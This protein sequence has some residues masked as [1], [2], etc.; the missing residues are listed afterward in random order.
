[1][2]SALIKRI[3]P[4]GLYGRAALILVVPIV[5]LQ[6]V[7]SLAFLQRHFE[8]ATWQMTRNIAYEISLIARAGRGFGR[9]R[10]GGGGGRAARGRGARDGGGAAGRA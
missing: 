8:G 7:V 5:T 9:C 10:R 6:L 2:I 3:L 1:M 4:R